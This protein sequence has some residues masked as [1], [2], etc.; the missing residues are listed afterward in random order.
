MVNSHEK[1]E[2]GPIQISK[3]I[4][5]NAKSLMEIQIPNSEIVDK[6]PH[7]KYG[8]QYTVICEEVFDKWKNI[9]EDL[10]VES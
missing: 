9:L 3:K 5:K 8:S 10:W 2:F 7:K 1:L 4:V 6:T